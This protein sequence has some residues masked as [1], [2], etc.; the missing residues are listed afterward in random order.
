[1]FVIWWGTKIERSRV[2]YV[3]EFCPICRGIQPFH[4]LRLSL[5][6]HVMEQATGPETPVGR[7]IRCANC[8]FE[9]AAPDRI[10]T[11]VPTLEG[12]GAAL[13]EEAARIHARRLEI[14]ARRERGDL[15]SEERKALLR[16]SF[17]LLEPLATN[18]ARGQMGEA[19]NLEADV[20]SIAF[21]LAALTCIMFGGAIYFEFPGRLG[22]KDPTAVMVALTFAG[23]GGLFLLRSLYLFST[24]ASRRVAKLAHPVLARALKP[25]RPSREELY[26]VLEGYR[27]AKHP[28]GR[29]VKAEALLKILT[30]P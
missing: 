6:R 19:E 16:E 12:V 7:T 18:A 1:M 5:V 30:A 24:A 25:I 8:D 28:L 22:K 14:E 11:S 29:Y 3:A 13:R 15:S 27:A 23:F 21:L 10:E 2:G 20:K 4:L 9:L 26:A 17:A